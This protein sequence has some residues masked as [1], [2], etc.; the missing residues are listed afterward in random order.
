VSSLP[1]RGADRVVPAS[2]LGAARR[3]LERG[4]VIAIP[5]DTVYGL[6]AR[7]DRPDALEA[8]FALK[9]RPLGLALP[10]LVASVAQGRQVAGEW[11]P[12]AAALARRLWP[13][14]L[15]VV[16]P[17]APWLDGRLGGDG[18]TVGLRL[19]DAAVVWDLCA[20][21]GP[22]AVTSANR[23]GEAP[24]VTAAG[25]T[26]VFAPEALRVV[27]DGGRCEGQPSTV[28]DCTVAPPRCLRQGGL[29][30][31]EVLAALP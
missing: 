17:A 6:A 4:G 29:G 19:P 9:G 22:L 2:S 25:C 28:A 13:G 30:W 11:P 26:A 24:C 31:P 14:A 23:H 21:A 20:E 18:A 12:Q 3:E 27:V 7:V 15:T 1:A 8:V 5:T 10:V 16:V